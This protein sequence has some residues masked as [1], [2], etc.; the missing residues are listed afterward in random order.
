MDTQEWNTRGVSEVV[1]EMLMIGLV[2][3]LIAVFSTTISSFLPT[4]RYP[5][6]TI[7]MTNETPNTITV[8]HNGGDW[9][10]ATD[11]RVIVKNSTDHA[12]ETIYRLDDSHYAFALVPQKTTFDLGSN[13]TIIWGSELD[14]NETVKLATPRAVIFSGQLGKGQ[15]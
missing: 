9:I 14:G 7:K 15:P 5:S 12:T 13:I 2:I 8:W 6:V 1:G 4:E 11:L 10:K 3:I